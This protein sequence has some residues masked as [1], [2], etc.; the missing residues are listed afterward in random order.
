MTPAAILNRI[1]DARPRFLRSERGNVAIFFTFALFPIIG[2]LGL[3]VDYG[4]AVSAKSTMQ[5][6]VD[7]TALMISK[8]A[9]SLTGA[10]ISTKAQ[11]YFDALFVK[12]GFGATLTTAYTPNAGTGAT[13]KIDASGTMQTDFMRVAGYPT[14]KITT[15]STTTWG[16]AR[17]RVALS[18]DNTGSMRDAGKMDALKTATKNLIDQLKTAATNTGDVYISIVPFSRAVNVG[19]SNKN[20]N[21]LR[22]TEWDAANGT[23]SNSSY[24]TKSSC[25]SSSRRTWT[26]KNHTNWNGC[27]TD[28]DQSNDVTAAAATSNA[29]RFPAEQYSDCPASMTGMSYSWTDLKDKVDTMSPAGATDQPIGLA[30]AWQ[31]LTA[32]SPFPYPAED[33]NYQYQKV[34]IHMSDGM[35]T[36]NR[37][38]GNGS[39]WSSAVDDR[40]ALICAN[41]KAA[42]IMLYMIQV[43][44]D[45]DPTQTVMQT[46]ASSADKFVMLTSGSQLISTFDNI[47]KQLAQLRIKK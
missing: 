47:G 46:C 38:N 27:V 12:P 43:N 6:A 39:R 3:A 9:A 30:W 35:N 45:G 34:V 18:L 20:A 8:E 44:T 25:E 32:G 37:W 4:R 26:P 24:T 1:R 33:A 21:W 22:W 15:S 29:T 10:Q 2:L 5:A 11:A 31:T 13:V 16:S 7:A 23:C 36:Q 14:L 40:Q 19:A 42:G 17:L 28:R 41:M